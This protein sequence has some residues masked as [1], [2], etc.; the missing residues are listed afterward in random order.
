MKLLLL[1]SVALCAVVISE[2][3]P[4]LEAVFHAKWASFKAQHG[5]SYDCDHE[6]HKRKQHFLEHTHHIESH[7]EKFHRGE[8]DF[9]VG[10]N[11]F[12][13]M[14]HEEFK[15]TRMGFNAPPPHMRENVTEFGSSLSA[16]SIPASVDWRAQC[17]DKVKNQ[18][19]C[20]SCYSF[21]ANG[22]LEGALARKHG[23]PFDLSEQ[24]L[25]DCS[26]GRNNGCEGGLMTTSF[27]HIKT[28]GGINHQTDYPY[29]GKVGTCAYKHAKKAA[30][31][32]S[33]VRV[34]ATENDLAV[35][36]STVGPVAVAMNAS[37][38]SVMMYKSGI[39]SDPSCT[40]SGLNH[41]VVCVGYG[42]E[43]GKAYWI[44]KNSWG[45]AWGEK[46]YIRIARNSNN[47][48][49]IASDACYPVL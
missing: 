31:I 35:A 26:Y 41:A 21:Y 36:V 25:V 20:G 34:R 46:G 3:A 18:G 13:D 14:S 28:A 22:A 9:K 16:P 24:N 43:N 23:R 10:H 47:M 30:S 6:E 1:V 44:I 12:S 49:G 8:V 48:C 39:L 19:Q 45:A 27:D 2:A 29:T 32:T 17:H 15:K 5:K 38:R 4:S 40:S 7:N 11:E 33:H 42:S 37:P